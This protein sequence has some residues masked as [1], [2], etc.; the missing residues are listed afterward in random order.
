MTS[1]SYRPGP[2]ILV[3]EWK[4]PHITVLRRL[5][6]ILRLLWRKLGLWRLTVTINTF[7]IKQQ[8][9]SH[10]NALSERL[11][12]TK[13]SWFWQLIDDIS[14]QFNLTQTHIYQRCQ[15]TSG[16]CQG[17]VHWEVYCDYLRWPDTVAA[18]IRDA[19]ETNLHT[20]L[21]TAL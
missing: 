16:A 1:L 10:V 15:L 4:C 5:P 14:Y 13:V 20:R 11:W 6:W 17:T 9:S 7:I 12:S 3:Y 2:L 19:S 21:S 8:K 18:N